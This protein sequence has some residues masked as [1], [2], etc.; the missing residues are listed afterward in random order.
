MGKTISMYDQQAVEVSIEKPANGSISKDDNISFDDFK[1]L[2]KGVI[3]LKVAQDYGVSEVEDKELWEDTAKDLYLSTK[4]YLPTAD[5]KPA[6]VVESVTTNQLQLVA[7]W[8]EKEVQGYLK[9]AEIYKEESKRLKEVSAETKDAYRQAVQAY[10][11][12]HNGETPTFKQDYRGRVYDD[13]AIQQAYKASD[14]AYI[15]YIN[16]TYNE[17]RFYA[18]NCY[19]RDFEAICRK[20]VDKH[21]DQLQ[22]KV[23]KKIGTITK[24]KHTGGD[25]YEFEG[26]NGKCIVEVVWAGGY[27]IQRLHTRWVVKNIVSE[28]IA[29]TATNAYKEFIEKARS[30]NEN[31]E[32]TFRM[33]GLGLTQDKIA[34]F[35]NVLLSSD[36]ITNI[37]YNRVPNTYTVTLKDINKPQKEVA[38]DEEKETVIVKDNTV[39]KI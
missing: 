6:K 12:E 23:E 29:L 35:K 3:D 30:E 22:A 17:N 13:D 16:Y 1:Q 32:Y 37:K 20:A 36:D 27:N 8:K 15:E 18:D 21:F 5:L 9:A 19:K 14:N 7:D 34:E 28:G 11:A 31:G 26:T 25:D 39:Q 24:I 33:D 10:S 4:Y 38:D 2:Y